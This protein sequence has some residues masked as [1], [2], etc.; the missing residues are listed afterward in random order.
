MRPKPLIPTR[1]VTGAAFLRR[2]GGTARRRARTARYERD[3]PLPTTLRPY[4]ARGLASNAHPRRCLC[5]APPSGGGCR[6]RAGLPHLAPDRLSGVVVVAPAA[7][8][9]PDH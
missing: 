4:R 7:T 9:T 6:F 5:A 2:R 3:R 8:M 1:T